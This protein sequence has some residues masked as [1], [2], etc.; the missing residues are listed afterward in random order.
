MNDEEKKKVRGLIPRIDTTKPVLA[1]AKQ[2]TD[3]LGSFCVA[4]E[5]SE[6]RAAILLA[7]RAFDALLLSRYGAVKFGE[8]KNESNEHIKE[9]YFDTPNVDRTYFDQKEKL[10]DADVVPFRRKKDP[11]ES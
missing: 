5:P 4:R 9:F 1:I 7:E 10:P 3:L 8:I 6:V 2:V 11:E